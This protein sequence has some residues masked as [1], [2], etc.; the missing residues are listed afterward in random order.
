MFT[1]VA[2]K[3]LAGAEGYFVEHFSQNDYYA[4]GEIS[5]GRWIGVGA[6]RL[7]L[8]AGH[9]VSR[10]QFC[11]LCENRNPQ[12]GERLTLRQNAQD[13][14]RVFFDFTCSAPKSVSVLAVTLDDWSNEVGHRM[15]AEE[16]RRY[17]AH[18][19][20]VHRAAL[21][22]GLSSR[23]RF[24]QMSQC[25]QCELHRSVRTSMIEVGRQRW[26]SRPPARW[27]SRSFRPSCSRLWSAGIS[28][29]TWWPVT[30]R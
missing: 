6:E 17:I 4:A 29:D 26:A 14:R 13:Q 19:R 22:R 27:P 1:A 5:P 20:R 18:S 23:P 7:G 16:D 11:A 21:C 3:S 25:T 2:H 24:F 12:T 10:D 30:R 8:S 15:S 9:E 28:R